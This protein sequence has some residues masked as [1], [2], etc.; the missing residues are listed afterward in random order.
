MRL[1]SV[2]LFP[3]NRNRKRKI[4]KTTGT[5][6]NLNCLFMPINAFHG[7]PY[8]IHIIPIFII[9]TERTLRDLIQYLLPDGLTHVN[10]CLRAFQPGTVVYA[11]IQPEAEINGF[12]SENLDCNI[13]RRTST[14]TR[15][16]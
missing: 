16:K 9:S 11:S 6:I 5:K 10:Y 15:R 4:S 8:Q 1:R 7:L 3:G 2:A 12:F 14:R 13:T